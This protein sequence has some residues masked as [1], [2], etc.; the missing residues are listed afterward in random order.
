MCI[1]I[2]VA[3]LIYYGALIGF[4]YCCAVASE[5]E[6]FFGLSVLTG[7]IYLFALIRSQQL[8]EIQ[9]FII[10]EFCFLAFV[11]PMLIITGLLAK[12][13][14]YIINSVL[15]LIETSVVGLIGIKVA[16]LC[17]AQVG[18]N[19]ASAHGYGAVEAAV[20]SRLP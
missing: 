1:V 2:A 12:P 14:Y 10:A 8:S 20:A 16:H 11:V 17:V 15:I 18:Q 9:A 7:I 3:A 5:N 4:Y 6:I 19:N 13:E